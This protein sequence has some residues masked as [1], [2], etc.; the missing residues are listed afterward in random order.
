MELRLGFLA[1]HKGS[2]VEAI[3]NEI[4]TGGLEAHARVIIS[5]NPNAHVLHIGKEANIP[6]YCLNEK[7]TSSID[8]TIIK[9]LK[10]HEVNLVILAGYMKQIEGGTIKTYKNRI[11]NIHPALLPKYGG[12]NMYGTA[13]HEAVINSNDRESGATVHIVTKE[14]D[15]G[16]IISQYKVPRYKQDTAETLAARVLKIEHVLYL[17]TLKD[18]QRDIISLD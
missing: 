16:K 17:Q 15:E 14:Y 18:I 3:L 1:S 7:N 2:N 8:D 11:L 13:V 10:D 6:N 9:I 5:N 12:R 4:K